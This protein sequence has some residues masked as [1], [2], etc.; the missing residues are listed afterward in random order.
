VLSLHLQLPQLLRLVLHPYFVSPQTLSS[1]SRYV[2][3]QLRL[4]RDLRPLRP[5]TTLRTSVSLVGP[6]CLFEITSLVTSDALNLLPRLT[7]PARIEELSQMWTHPDP[8]IHHYRVPLESRVWCVIILLVPSRARDHVTMTNGARVEYSFCVQSCV[9]CCVP[10]HGS[11]SARRPT[12]RCGPCPVTRQRR[13]ACSA[14]S[15]TATFRSRA[16]RLR[17]HTRESL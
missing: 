5:L 11:F 13:H 15:H 8:H 2:P 9:S 6:V 3:S 10:F 17:A 1:I 7:S 12:S 14:P 16:R 4:L